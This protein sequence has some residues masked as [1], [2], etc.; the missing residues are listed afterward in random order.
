MFSVKMRFLE[1]M[2]TFSSEL[3]SL[4][5]LLVHRGRKKLSIFSDT[6]LRK[7]AYYSVLVKYGS[8]FLHLPFCSLLSFDFVFTV[9]AKH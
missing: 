5:N 6:S 1:T 7:V 8:S 3:I 2:Y 9:M 4:F